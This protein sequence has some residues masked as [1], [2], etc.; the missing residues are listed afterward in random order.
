[1]AANTNRDII[2]DRLRVLFFMLMLVDHTLHGYAQYWGDKWFVHDIDRHWIWDIFY[3]HNNSV[4]IPMLFFVSGACVPASLQRWGIGQYLLRRGV[5]LLGV[6]VLGVLFLVPLM[7]YGKFTLQETD[8][9]SLWVFYTKKFLTGESLQAG[10]MWVLYA[11]FLYSLI[12]AG[13]MNLFSRESLRDFGATLGDFIKTR[14]LFALG[15]VMGVCAVLL[16]VMDIRF[17]AP[18]WIGFGKVFHF[19]AS[20]FLVQALFFFIGVCFALIPYDKRK[21][22]L[23]M[24]VASLQPLLLALAVSGVTYIAYAMLWFKDGAYSSDLYYYY[25]GYLKGQD[26][27]EILSRIAPGVLLRTTLH[28]IF[29]P[30]QIVCYV[31]VAAWA[32]NKK[33]EYVD[34]WSDKTLGLFLYHPIFVIWGQVALYG[35]EVPTLLKII[36]VVAFAYIGTLVATTATHSWIPRRIRPTS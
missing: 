5:Y 20:R 32:A 1:M 10:P 14:P 15:I 16:G 18:W 26:P 28:A 13:V 2:L 24:V 29:L 8:S 30:L 3:L 17:G 27:W 22:I 23:S 6:A 31:G 35:T 34:Y 19:Q 21:E 25:L 4:I 33:C 11:I 36:C 12:S 9:A 7:G